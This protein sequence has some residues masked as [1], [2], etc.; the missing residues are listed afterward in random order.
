LSALYLAN[1]LHAT[2]QQLLPAVQAANPN[3][4][5]SQDQTTNS[6][7]LK[8]MQ[9]CTMAWSANL[10]TGISPDD[11]ADVLDL[12]S[13]EQPTALAATLLARST[14]VKFG[15]EA[16]RL[17]HKLTLQL[18]QFG[19][20]LRPHITAAVNHLWPIWAKQSGCILWAKQSGCIPLPI[21]PD[22]GIPSLLLYPDHYPTNAA[23]A[24]E[25][26]APGLLAVTATLRHLQAAADAPQ[27]CAD[28][29]S[30][31]APLNVQ[32]V[33]G[34]LMDSRPA[35]VAEAHEF[36]ARLRISWPNRNLALK[37]GTPVWAWQLLHLIGLS[38]S[39][40]RFNLFLPAD[41]LQTPFSEQLYLL[42]VERFALQSIIVDPRGR[43]QVEFAAAQEMTQL[44]LVPLSG[45]KRRIETESPLPYAA[46]RLTLLLS[47]PLLQLFDRGDLALLDVTK[48]DPDPAA[49]GL[50]LRSTPGRTLWQLLQPKRTLPPTA[51]AVT[52]CRRHGI[53]LPRA[54]MLQALAKLADKR[55]ATTQ[56]NLDR[57]IADWLG[58]A[59]MV[60]PPAPMSSRTDQRPSVVDDATIAAAATRDGILRFPADFLYDIPQAE[61]ARFSAGGPLKIV[62]T[63]FDAITLSTTDGASLQVNHINTA[64]AL[65]LATSIK[66]GNEIEL[67]HSG[68]LT[69]SLL[70]RYGAHLHQ[71]RTALI[72][73]AAAHH[74]A[75]VDA[76]V[77]RI[78][79]SLP[80]PPWALI[81][82]HL[83]PTSS[84]ML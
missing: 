47:D 55:P 6:L 25:V 1:L 5:S 75:D 16:A 12:A 59:C 18:H 61:R 34:A 51:R 36:N 24:V 30:L 67:P 14:P 45:I 66:N 4:K 29:L 2:F 40:A 7:L 8:F 26:A 11:L 84:K 10:P 52:D 20:S 54:E 76:T 82:E 60:S 3:L 62:E 69:E 50:F 71:L 79:T 21:L 80:V 83:P 74:A 57:E 9:L 23:V 56:A 39:T 32:Q 77:E 68:R 37:S 19:P 63:F 48:P 64:R 28:P 72:K 53:P 15:G 31:V 49:I 58:T 78:W 43:H 73:A 41:W 33:A 46:L 44:D 17:L 38:P 70:Q 35:T 42:L 65:L 22:T 27:Q 13:H 81:T